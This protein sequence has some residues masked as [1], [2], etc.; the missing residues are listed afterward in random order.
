MLAGGTPCIRKVQ[1]LIKGC[2]VSGETKWRREVFFCERLWPRSKKPPRIRYTGPALEPYGVL[3][4]AP[5]HT[6]HLLM[7]SSTS[8]R[9]RI[10]LSRVK[11]H[12]PC[13]ILLSPG[14]EERSKSSTNSYHLSESVWAAITVSSPGGLKSQT[15]ISQ[16]SGGWKS[17]IGVS[18][19][20]FWGELSS[21][22]AGS[23]L[24][25]VCSCRLFSVYARGEGTLSFSA[26]KATHPVL[27]IQF[28]LMI[29]FNWI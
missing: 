24:L 20:W 4:V 15:F 12:H 9:K 23:H 18:M 16:S 27:T 5:P 25:T 8:S 6:V 10:R 26:Y 14:Q 19:V 28:N 29:Q 2:T 3:A 1:H 17:E 21:Q 11:S 22:L 7:L 13:T